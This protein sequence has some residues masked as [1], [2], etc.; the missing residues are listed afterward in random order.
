MRYFLQKRPALQLDPS[1]SDASSCESGASTITN[2]ISSN[3]NR[4]HDH[5][6][7]LLLGTN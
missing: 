1:V 7:M 3:G 6:L 5:A 2:A 4:R